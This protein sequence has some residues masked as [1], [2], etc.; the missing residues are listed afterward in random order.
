[1]KKLVFLDIDGTLSIPIDR[2]PASAKA[3]CRAARRNGHL[4]FICTGRAK[5]EIAPKVLDIGFDGVVSAS[6]AHIEIGGDVIHS[7][8][9]ERGLLDRLTAF[10]DERGLVYVTESSDRIVASDFLFDYYLKAARR[11]PL[12]FFKIAAFVLFLRRISVG[13]KTLADEH[14]RNEACKLV[15]MAEEEAAY[16]EVERAFGAE[17]ELCRNS[18]PGMSGGEVSTKGVHKGAAVEIVMRHYG[19]ARD[20]VFAFGDGDNDRT[21]LTAAGHGIAM[22][23]AIASLKA[24]ADDIAGRVDRNGLALA[25]RKYG[26]V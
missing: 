25:F 11:N 3:A 1:M 18:I 5:L 2:V 10:L 13:E 15:F 20:D 22:G 8:A 21:M 19:M 6:G 12:A 7:V 4:L 24:I 9:M 26:L 17:C 16:T 14:W 23:N